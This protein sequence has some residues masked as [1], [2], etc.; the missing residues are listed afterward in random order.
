MANLPGTMGELQRKIESAAQHLTQLRAL[1]PL[2]LRCA[3]G[4][5]A[6]RE[7]RAP[8]ACRRSPV[9]QAGCMPAGAPAC[10][11]GGTAQQPPR[12]PAHGGRAAR[13]GSPAS[14]PALSLP[15]SV[16]SSPR[17]SGML[18]CRCAA[19]PPLPP[20]RGARRPAAAPTPRA[21]QAGHAHGAGHPR[22]GAPRGRPASQEA[23]ALLAV[24]NRGVAG[25]AGQAAG[26]PFGPVWVGWLG[27]QQGEARA[28]RGHLP[29]GSGLSGWARAGHRAWGWLAGSPP[30][31][32]QRTNHATDRPPVPNSTAGGGGGAGG[33]ARAASKPSLND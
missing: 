27:R 22:P 26:A 3:A 17:C 6:G 12:A 15:S 28:E 2:A 18:V 25:E 32:N 20:T 29:F 19:L 8:R 10:G 11:T 33:A 9:L 16:P 24:N 5:G 21:L 1:Q 14:N 23:G 30:P 7:P 13:A 31:S 4:R